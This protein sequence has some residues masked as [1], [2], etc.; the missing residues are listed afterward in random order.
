MTRRRIR[1]SG[2]FAARWA[3]YLVAA[4]VICTEAANARCRQAL[5]LG[6]DVSGS[7]DATEY[8]L[9]MQGLANAL[10]HPEV[11]AALLGASAA[12]VEIA[13]YEWSAPDYQ[14][15][16]V[17]WTAITDDA[18][19]QSV[20]AQIAATPRQPAPPV[21]GLGQAML[22]GQNLL[23]QRADCWKRTLDISGDGRN[24]SGPDPRD[25]KAVLSDMT[26]NA[27]V[28]GADAPH[29]GDLRQ[30]EIAELSSYFRA[31]VIFGP[32]A[33][34]ETAIGFEDYEEAMVR[35]LIRELETL[36]V[37]DAAKTRLSR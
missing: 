22:F 34:V 4:L 18:T 21:T 14:R 30:V 33:F 37:S 17:A 24:N 27:L 5:A 8:R 16:L 28:I 29:G 2:T 3:V 10:R 25:V 7:V 32:D 19:L 20:A 1:F 23:R 35:K 13:V 11:R 36:I 6:L 9:Q 15:I 12:P 26:L 31:L